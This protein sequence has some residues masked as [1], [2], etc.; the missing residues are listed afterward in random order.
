MNIPDPV[1]RS[2]I[3]SSQL[4]LVRSIRELCHSKFKHVQVHGDPP[5]SIHPSI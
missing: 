1:I 2:L 5:Q 3:S 4:N